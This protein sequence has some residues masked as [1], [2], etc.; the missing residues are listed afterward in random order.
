VLVP[1]VSHTEDLL[2]QQLACVALWNLSKNR[3][4]YEQMLLVKGGVS[5]KSKK[6]SMDFGIAEK[7][8]LELHASTANDCALWAV[9]TALL[10]RGTTSS[11]SSR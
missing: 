4:V 10:G 5:H 6:K 11:S 9:D 3:S 8:L 7:R 2:H 1:A